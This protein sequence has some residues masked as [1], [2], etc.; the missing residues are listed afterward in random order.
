[1]FFTELA[2]LSSFKNANPLN[3][4]TLSCISM[5]NQECKARP[6]IVNVNSNKPYFILLVSKQINVVAIAIILM[7]HMQEFVFL[8]LQK[9]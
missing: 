5:S 1:M 9:I 8:T 2:I 6:G 4:T 3:A 7:T